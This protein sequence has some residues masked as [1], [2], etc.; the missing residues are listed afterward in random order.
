M[1]NDIEHQIR[2]IRSLRQTMTE[3]QVAA[4]GAS[5]LLNITPKDSIEAIDCECILNLILFLISENEDDEKI[6]KIVGT[7][8][9]MQRTNYHL[10][11][12]A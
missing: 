3:L 1:H 9:I 12:G 10:K 8:P 2:F 5:I 4:L 6:T 7:F 11:E